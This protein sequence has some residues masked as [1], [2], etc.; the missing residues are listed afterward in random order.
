[1]PISKHRNSNAWETV[2]KQLTKM[3]K[4]HG[5]SAYRSG[6]Q[7][8]TR[9][10][11]LEDEYK[12]V[13]DHNNRS[14]QNRETFEYFEDLDS[15]LGCKPS[16]TPK[17]VLECGLGD[18]DEPASSAT[19]PVEN[20]NESAAEEGTKMVGKEDFDR[21][22]GRKRKAKGRVPAGKAKK[23]ANRDDNENGTLIS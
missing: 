8:K 10:K 21:K 6:S 17:S 18:D 15:V 16:I 2:A 20:E 1:M 22:S 3:L 12:K 19:S 13:K 11:T 23:P 5:M 14:S 7:C 9:M 4:E